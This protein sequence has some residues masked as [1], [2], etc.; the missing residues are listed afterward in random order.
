MVNSL[1]WSFLS[2]YGDVLKFFFKLLVLIVVREKKIVFLWNMEYDDILV[3]V[4]NY[5]L[6]V[7]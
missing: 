2:D 7:C 4:D 1:I 3:K 6:F 5:E